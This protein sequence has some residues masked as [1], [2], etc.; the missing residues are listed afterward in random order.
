MDRRGNTSSCPTVEKHSSSV[1]QSRY[2]G[3]WW[4]Y[5]INKQVCKCQ[6]QNSFNFYVCSLLKEITCLFD[7]K[8]LAQFL[9]SGGIGVPV[10]RWWKE[11]VVPTGTRMLA[12]TVACPKNGDRIEAL[13]RSWDLL[14]TTTLP[15]LQALM[16]PLNVSWWFL[17]WHILDDQRVCCTRDFL[18]TFCV[19][20]IIINFWESWR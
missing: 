9:L 14:Y 3:S 16:A 11:E 15:L 7:F 2:V 10:E 1:W 5:I 20:V 12:V 8:Q 18:S 6:K 19:S 13:L 17:N 4:E